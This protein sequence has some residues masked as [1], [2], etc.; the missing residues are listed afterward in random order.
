MKAVSLFVK[1]RIW[2]AAVACFVTPLAVV[3]QN[4]DSSTTTDTTKS[5]TPGP[6]AVTG[7]VTSSYTYGTQAQGHDIVGRL[8]N[9]RHNE[10]MLNVADLT[11]ERVAATDR[12]DAGFH[13][14]GFFG[15]N[16]EVVKSVGLDL[17]HDADIWQ[18]Y[19]TL[20]WPLGPGAYVQFKGG[21][22]ATLMGVEVGEDVVNPNLDVGW[23][24]VLLEPFT[25][26]GAELDAKFGPHA[27]VEL[28]VS[29]GWD[30]V[31]DIN[32]GKTVMARLGLT[33]D[34]QTLIAL[35]GYLGP[36]QA[37]NAHDKRFGANAV[38]SRKITPPANAWLQLDYG[39]EQGIAA[40]GGDAKWYAAG[41]WVTYDV[42][43]AATLA[44]RGDYVN[45][46]DGARS[47]GALGFPVNTG[48]KFGSATATLNIKSWAHALVRPEIR[49]D[50]SDLSVF[51]GKDSQIT[52]GLGY[53]YI[54]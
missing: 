18:A 35:V 50:H 28:R 32:T 8:Y 26:T 11:V 22:L 15:Q 19:V 31:T 6:V 3:A 17:G 33:P 25:E 21:K 46:R 7:Y 40:N 38:L 51:K 14:E 1:Y 47:S 53:S 41:F 12:M 48:Q 44:F 5:A 9:R 23:Q 36:E 20:N 24:D 39:Q 30:Q 4:A 29:N 49:Y 16:A 45:D 27:D 10:F 42:A 52:F 2:L 54:F 34:D 13:F 37:G 43:P